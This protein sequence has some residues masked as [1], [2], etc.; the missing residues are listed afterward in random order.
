MRR[1]TELGLRN[2]RGEKE[3]E[4]DD[5]SA[6]PL[7]LE[8]VVEENW[9]GNVARLTMTNWANVMISPIG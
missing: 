6:L 5:C 1:G 2:Q 7:G 8:F 3:E 9:V 4:E